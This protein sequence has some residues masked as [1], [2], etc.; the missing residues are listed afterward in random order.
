MAKVKDLLAT[1]ELSNVGVNISRYDKP[2][3]E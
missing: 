3:S 2:F 1:A